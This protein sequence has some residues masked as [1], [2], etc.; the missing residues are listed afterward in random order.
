MSLG[1][2]GQAARL[3]GRLVRLEPDNTRNE[4]MQTEM[5]RM[6]KEVS[7]EIEVESAPKKAV[8]AGRRKK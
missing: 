6:A 7:R 8:G 3:F 5:Q 2:Y 4:I 1:E